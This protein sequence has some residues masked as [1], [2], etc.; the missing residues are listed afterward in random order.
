M[1]EYVAGA[2]D[3]A[4]C[5]GRNA[6]VAAKK[7]GPGKPGPSGREVTWWSILS[8]RRCPATGLAAQSPNRGRSPLRIEARAL[9]IS[10][11]STLAMKRPNKV[12]EGTWPNE[13]AVLDMMSPFF[14]ADR[15]A[16]LVA[17][18][19]NLGIPDASTTRLFA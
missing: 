3:D 12:A 15:A 7:N 1:G 10:R 5:N 14:A 9:A 16:W 18:G 4:K 17:T 19:T 11:R 8:R 2:V 13:E 6:G